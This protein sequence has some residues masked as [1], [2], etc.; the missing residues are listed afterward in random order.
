MSIMIMLIIKFLAIIILFHYI[1]GVPTLQDL[2][3]IKNSGYSAVQYITSVFN[4]V[5]QPFIMFMDALDQEFQKG[6]V[7]MTFLCFVM[8]GVSTGRLPGWEVVWSEDL[9]THISGG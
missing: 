9:F 8:S 7:E 6:T 2:S 3:F 5:K 4:G 1:W